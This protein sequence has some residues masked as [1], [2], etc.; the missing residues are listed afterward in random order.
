MSRWPVRISQTGGEPPPPPVDSQD[1]F[2]PKYLVGNTANGDS[3]V[4]YSVA[5]FR[6]IPDT[7]NG[8]GIKL[9]LTQPNGPGDV[10]IRPGYYD[11]AA[12]GS[13]VTGPLT[14]PVNT[15]VM[16]AG[17]Y[18]TTV[19]GLPAGDAG[20]FIM[21]SETMLRDIR[22][23][24]AG[25]D[26]GSPAVLNL[27]GAGT[28][29]DNVTVN[30]GARGAFL[31]EAIRV[32]GGSTKITNC[33][34][35]S[36]LGVR[37]LEGVTDVSILGCSFIISSTGNGIV[38]DQITGSASES[39]PNVRV[40]SC[41]I[42]VSTNGPPEAGF[43]YG[44]LLGGQYAVVNGCTIDLTTSSPQGI[45][46]ICVNTGL[47][48]GAGFCGSVLSNNIIRSGGQ[49][50]IQVAD[51]ARTAVT[52]NNIRMGDIGDI[53]ASVNAIRVETPSSFTTVLGNTL[54]HATASPSV[55]CESTRCAVTG[56]V[57]N[58]STIGVQLSAASTNNVV[59]S[60][61]TS[62]ATPVSNLGTSNEV[63]HNV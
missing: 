22:V 17:P 6:Y 44:I 57:I 15:R 25:G 16:G 14:I 53:P 23:S 54:F 58:A 45:A 42:T 62:A 18:A 21:S 31:S 24:G 51:G 43:G 13:T 61:T 47:G 20:V 5:G 3:P 39:L 4:G 11:F 30:G 56:N 26:S 8:N 38:T 55:F 59:V 32:Q 48:L 2:S 41:H 52:G 63:A 50:G 60:N 35:A 40:E 9:A 33:R 29:L 28:T 10:Y 1:R 34:V 27:A 36:Y 49:Y 46:G 19:L 7:G 12:A 37:V